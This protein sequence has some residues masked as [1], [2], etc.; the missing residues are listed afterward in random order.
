MNAPSKTNQLVNFCSKP[1]TKL[2]ECTSIC[3]DDHQVENLI[4]QHL[5]QRQKGFRVEHF[6]RPPVHL[7]FHF[8]VPVDIACVVIKPDLAEGSEVS[9]TM[10]LSHS[11]SQQREQQMKLCGRGC[12][13]GEGAVLVIKN[14]VFERRHQCKVELSMFPD[15]LASQVNQTDT[16]CISEELLKDVFNVRCLKLSINYFSG[17]RP[18][19]VKW[20]EVWGTLGT[21]TNR[22]EAQAAG[23]AISSLMKRKS[24]GG[25]RALR[26]AHFAPCPG[27]GPRDGLFCQPQEGKPDG[28]H[29]EA[30]EENVSWMAATSKHARSPKEME[31]TEEKQLSVFLPSQ[32][33]RCDGTTHMSAGNSYGDK[34]E[35]VFTGSGSCDSTYPVLS[36]GSSALK[37]STINADRE[38]KA[39]EVTVVVPDRFLDEITYEI[40]ALPMLLPSGHCVDRSTL[41]K[42]HHTDSIYGRPPS[43][44]FTG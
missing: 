28:L 20:V 22:D 21:V 40:M 41:D 35:N 16:V 37:H 24:D 3:A 31:K 2:V 17:P 11:A 8:L 42:L 13:K 27:G 10:F 25:G 43:D 33:Q 44:P 5:F 30:V 1:L 6:I 39:K 12:V 26:V 29:G 23:A 32:V 9:L 34:P 36:S 7:F 15:V 18:V 38:R 14:R 4:S 19:S